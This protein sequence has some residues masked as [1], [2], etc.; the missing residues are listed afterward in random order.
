MFPSGPRG[1][2]GDP[3]LDGLPGLPGRQGPNGPPGPAGLPG[4]TGQKVCV[5]FSKDIVPV[6]CFF[7]LSY[8]NYALMFLYTG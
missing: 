1:E 4:L 7:F 2:K 8:E 6:K 5:F 3:G